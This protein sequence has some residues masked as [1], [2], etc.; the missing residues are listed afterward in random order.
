[1][2]YPPSSNLAAMLTA[3]RSP[4]T[5]SQPTSSVHLRMPI[6]EFFIT[7]FIFPR[8]W[9]TLQHRNGQSKKTLQEFVSR[10]KDK[11]PNAAH[12]EVNQQDKHEDV[13]RCF[14]RSGAWLSLFTSRCLMHPTQTPR[15]EGNIPCAENI[16]DFPSTPLSSTVVLTQSRHQVSSGFGFHLYPPTFSHPAYFKKKMTTGPYLRTRAAV[17]STGG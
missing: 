4:A 8:C 17:L 1:V 13:T 16:G 6:C 2:L 14:A 15:V 5:S 12:G 10:H 9:F 7:C 3:K 11:W